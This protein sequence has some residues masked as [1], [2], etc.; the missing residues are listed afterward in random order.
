MRRSA[1]YRRSRLRRSTPPPCRQAWKS[2]GARFLAHLI[3]RLVLVLLAV[4]AVFAPR[5][6]GD[7]GVV[8]QIAAA[9]LAL[10]WMLFVWWAFAER[11]AG[12]GMRL[13]RL[14][15]VGFY[16]GRPIGWIRF[17]LR[18][19]VLAA[20][21]ATGIG[22]LLMLIFL[23]MHPRKQGW[24]DLL[25]HA[26]VIKQRALAPKSK[27]VAEQR[28][29]EA[30]T[31][32]QQDQLAGSPSNGGQPHPSPKPLARPVAG[33]GPPPVPAGPHPNAAQPYGDPSPGVGPAGSPAAIR[34][35]RRMN[36]INSVDRSLRAR[37]LHPAAHSPAGVAAATGARRRLLQVRDVSAGA[38]ND[39]VHPG[40]QN[41]GRPV[42]DQRRARGPVT[43][44]TVDCRTGIVRADGQTGVR[45]AG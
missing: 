43:G 2:V 37:P 44:F 39:H 27:V 40:G 21:T 25:V 16:D 12:P 1:W 34:R 24:H 4:A 26:V 45:R 10:A 41:D 3:D 31:P 18:A 23:V 22:L 29:T 11:A 6:G 38:A 5:V 42:T 9:V 35:F 30:M 7:I 13:M 33:Y 36:R 20:L 32:A 19:L 17:L 15:L 8:I 28:R 14:Q